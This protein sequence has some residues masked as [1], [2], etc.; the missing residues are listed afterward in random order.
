MPRDLI[1][2]CGSEALRCY[3]ELLQNKPDVDH[4]MLANALSK[5]VALRD[6]FLDE[7]RID[8][9]SDEDE[10]RLRNTNSIISYGFSASFP[11]A[12][13]QWKRIEKTVEALRRLVNSIGRKASVEKM[14]M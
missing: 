14:E 7:R 8:N 3:E 1:I 11:L 2:R 13:V 9:L 4:R 6:A 10:G 12:G 5:L